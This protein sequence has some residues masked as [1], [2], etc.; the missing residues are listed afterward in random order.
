MVVEI[1][2]IDPRDQSWEVHQPDYRVYFFEPGSSAEYELRRVD[3]VEVLQW[4]ETECQG[5]PFVIYA[6]AH[7][8]VG[9]GLLR[10]FG[11]DPNTEH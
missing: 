2:T 1:T 3:V 10:L 6:C 7:T 9:L 4:A 8:G 5:R 11:T